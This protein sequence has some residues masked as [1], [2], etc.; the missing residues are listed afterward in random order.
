[1]AFDEATVDRVRRLFEGSPGYAERRMFGGL[2]F[3]VR[4]AYRR[5]QAEAGIQTAV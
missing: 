5:H 2:T 3:M 1:M 4:E